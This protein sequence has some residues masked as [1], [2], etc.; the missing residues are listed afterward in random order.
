[1]VP[2]IALHCLLRRV[3][4]IT[5]LLS[6]IN[7]ISLCGFLSVQH[8][9]VISDIAFVDAHPALFGCNSTLSMSHC[10]KILVVE[11]DFFLERARRNGMVVERLI[12][13]YLSTVGLRQISEL[14]RS[15]LF[16][17]PM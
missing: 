12:R 15:D 13:D 10:A 5:T 4:F 14:R 11:M 6:A 3:R 2:S 16:L 1:M 7:G 9:Q 17:L 8:R